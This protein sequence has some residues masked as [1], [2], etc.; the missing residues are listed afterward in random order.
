M[1]KWITWLLIIITLTILIIYIFIPS[2]IVISEVISSNTPASA[3]FRFVSQKGRWEKWWRDENGKAHN[4]NEPFTYNGVIFRLTRLGFNVAGIEIEK[5]G[6]TIE[7]E[8]QLLSPKRDTTWTIWRCEMPESNNPFSRVKQYKKAIELRRNMNAVLINLKT[9]LSNPLNVYEMAI[10]RTSFRDTIMLS[11]LFS[12]TS[13]PSTE[14]IYRYFDI[15]KKNIQNQ[16]GQVT[17]YPMM[18]V[19]QLKSDSFETQV[20]LPTDRILRGDGK[21]FY[22]KMIPG[23]FLCAIVKGGTSAVNESMN[24]LQFF[25][26]DNNKIQMAIPFQQLVTDRIS[27]PDSS[28]WITRVYLPVVE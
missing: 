17:G 19:Q 6:I 13:Y 18:N 11:T 9:Y 26:K 20:A 27:E 3:E 2:K 10:F 16:K 1:K 21:I 7:S 5:D 23:N 25:L 22:R 12:S 8:M 28:K 15:V 14:D 24:Q 4:K